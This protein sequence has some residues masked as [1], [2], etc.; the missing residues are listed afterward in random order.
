MNKERIYLLINEKKERILTLNEIK[1]KQLES[2]K[3]SLR[4]NKKGNFL[5]KHIKMKKDKIIFV[6]SNHQSIIFFLFFSFLVLGF[7]MLIGSHIPH[8]VGYLFLPLFLFFFFH[9]YDF[10]GLIIKWNNIR[11]IKKRDRKTLKKQMGYKKLFRANSEFL[12]NSLD[13]K[14]L[15]DHVKTLNKLDEEIFPKK[16]KREDGEDLL[17]MEA[18]EL[19]YSVDVL[20]SINYIENLFIGLLDQDAKEI[21]SKKCEMIKENNKIDIANELADFQKEIKEKKLVENISIF[22]N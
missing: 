12:K 15:E 18:L 21:F 8:F 1:S 4:K 16:R 7:L 20:H 13:N 6:N 17:R 10:V 14:V 11:L 3:Y 2:P 19:I 22:E 5:S 9:L